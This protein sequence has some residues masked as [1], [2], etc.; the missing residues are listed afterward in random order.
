M[1]N[2][3]LTLFFACPLLF[4]F[5]G[6]YYVNPQTDLEKQ[7]D[8]LI[9]QGFENLHDGDYEK[10]L[11]S[12]QKIIELMP[13]HPAGYFY[14]AAAVEWLIIDHKNF[15][16]QSVF[17]EH[18]EKAISLAKKMLKKNKKDTTGHFYL[19]AAYGFRGVYAA[20]YGSFL[21]AF[22]DGLKAYRELKKVLKDSP[23]IY[24][25][26][27][28]VGVYEFYKAYY[29]EKF[30]WLSGSEAT[31]DDGIEKVLISVEKGKYGS[32]E[33][34]LT[35]LRMYY[36]DE[37][38]DQVV[39]RAEKLIERFPNYLFC[40]WFLA[41]TYADIGEHEKSLNVYKKIRTLLEVS[42]YSNSFS[43][44]E[45]DYHIAHA[46]FREGQ[47]EKAF[48]MTKKLLPIVDAIDSRMKYVNKFVKKT[49]G[50][51]KEIEEV[52]KKGQQ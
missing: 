26:Y 10:S 29:L 46:L 6:G 36:E 23:E 7:V 16:Y 35:L 33:A 4:S 24:D 1:K 14:Y 30:L 2:L 39:G 21:K 17:E 11:N 25:A 18:I 9:F 50:L 45:V 15:D 48:E 27:Y 32:V 52:I 49:K 13:D 38:L 22:S 5:V 31:K 51:H 37:R 43:F 28:G 19:G 34:E 47:T 12:F 3:I 42:P 20:D 8:Q 41:R 44:L 40:Y